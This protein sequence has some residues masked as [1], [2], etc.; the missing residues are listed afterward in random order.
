MTLRLFLLAGALAIQPA[1][2]RS[3]AAAALPSPDTFFAQPIGSDYYLANYREYAAYLHA[4][5]AKSDRMKL[6]DIGK[7]AEG[8]TQW[9]AIVSSPA[10]LARLDEYR[11][12]A[13]KLARGRIGEAEARDLAK[14]GKAVVWIDAGLHATETVTSQ[15]QI[16]V[17]HRMLS[18]SDAE[19]LRMLDDC[20]I[21][22]AHDNPDGMDLVS[23]WYM[24]SADPKKREFASLPRLYQKYAGHDNN[25]DS[26]MS[27]LAETANV[28]RVL[29]RQ[30][31]PQIVYNQHQTGPDGMVV[32]IPPFRDPSNPNYD[33]LVMAGLNEVGFAMQ[34]RLIEEGKP[35]GG[36]RK[37][38]V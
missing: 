16:Q 36:R 6:V 23:D 34:S 30:W 21:L 7:S 3:C 15:G 1:A 19:T 38:R 14:R 29:F 12:I 18:Q 20:I 32:F 9:M 33:P 24:R 13:E 28:N 26:Y 37:G 2:G 11:G 10:N 5:A 27:Q 4:L 25:R 17:L 31:Y 35:G 22:F 8:R